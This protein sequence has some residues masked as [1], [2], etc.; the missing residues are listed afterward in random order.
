M[1]IFVG[2]ASLPPTVL[3]PLAAAHAALG[4]WLRASHPAS[5]RAGMRRRRRSSVSDRANASVVAAGEVTDEQAATRQVSGGW[6]RA[7]AIDP[8]RCGL[9]TVALPPPVPRGRACTARIAPTCAVLP[10]SVREVGRSTYF[11]NGF[12]PAPGPLCSTRPL[13]LTSAANAPASVTRTRLRLSD[14]ANVHRAAA[15]IGGAAVCR[16]TFVTAMASDTPYTQ[17]GL[18][19][20]R[21]PPAHPRRCC[22]CTCAPGHAPIC[23]R[24]LIPLRR[25]DRCRTAIFCPHIAVPQAPAAKRVNLNPWRLTRSCTASGHAPAAQNCPRSR[26]RLTPW[27]RRILGAARAVGASE[28]GGLKTRSGERKSFAQ[29]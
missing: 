9:R 17:P 21:A 1:R 25:P 16:P 12:W 10:P 5:G 26:T 8:A 28:A 14:R 7:R 3:P 15:P 23:R 27:L 20:S 2:A 19:V 11:C 29:S 13:R 18:C 6:Q 4:A 24:C 22:A